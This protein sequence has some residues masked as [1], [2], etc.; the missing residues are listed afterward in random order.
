MAHLIE[1][2]MLDYPQRFGPDLAD[3][4]R[5]WGTRWV[6]RT[7][8]RVGHLYPRVS[9]SD[10]A[11]QLDFGGEERQQDRAAGRPIAYL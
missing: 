6:D 10:E 4:I 11:D 9:G 3:D 1:L 8:D 7:W 5:E 2:C